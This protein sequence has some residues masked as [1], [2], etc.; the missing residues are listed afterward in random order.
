MFTGGDKPLP[1]NAGVVVSGTLATP[2]HKRGL[3]NDMARNLIGRLNNT[4]QG[5]R[6]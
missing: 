5:K 4:E 1:Y 3:T 2:V 6:V